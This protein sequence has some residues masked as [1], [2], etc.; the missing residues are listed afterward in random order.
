MIA[1]VATK[2]AKYTVPSGN[3]GI[4]KR[5]IPYVPS[6]SLS[7]ARRTDPTVGAST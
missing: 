5:T 7:T 2:G 4:E 1:K 6:F 3:S